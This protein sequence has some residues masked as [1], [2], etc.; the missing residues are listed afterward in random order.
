M[1]SSRFVATIVRDGISQPA[2]SE[3]AR[4]LGLDEDREDALRDERDRQLDDEALDRLGDDVITGASVDGADAPPGLRWV[5]VPGR[6]GERTKGSACSS[7][8]GPTRPPRTACTLTRGFN[9]VSRT[10]LR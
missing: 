3:Q 9:Y 2:G 5:L 1:S 10:Q 4:G 6:T 7:K 8:H